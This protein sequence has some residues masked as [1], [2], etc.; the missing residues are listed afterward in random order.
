MWRLYV[1][2]QQSLFELNGVVLTCAFLY[3]NVCTYVCMRLCTIG[4]FPLESG[5]INQVVK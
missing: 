3:V 5:N 1:F 4:R 2:H